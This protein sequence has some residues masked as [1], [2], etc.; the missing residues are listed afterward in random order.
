MNSTL[1]LILFVFLTVCQ[2]QAFTQTVAIG[3]LRPYLDTLTKSQKLD[4]L[5]YMRHLGSSL[6]REVAQSYLQ[7]DKNQQERALQYV[8]LQLMQPQGVADDRTTVRFAKDTLMLGKVEEG[9]IIIDSFLVTNTGARPYLIKEVKATCDCTILRRPEYPVMPGE[10]AAI[11]VEFDTRGKI[12][13]TTPGVVLYDNTRPNG[14]QI[15]YLQA[16]VVPRVKP[17]NN[18]GGN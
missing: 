10:T 11:R 7:L 14:R 4:L 8:R 18:M 5:E 6:D 17:R 3:E 1:R 9:D 15:V 2:E 16:E 12:G 13:R